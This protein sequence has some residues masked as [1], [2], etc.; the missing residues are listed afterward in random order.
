MR[1][2]VTG[3]GGEPA[4]DLSSD[5]WSV[6]ARALET[7]GF[8]LV[9]DQ[10]GSSFD[11]LVAMNHSK[12]AID[13]S[14]RLGVPI[15]KRALILWEPRVVS[16]GMYNKKI[17]SRYGFVYSPSPLRTVGTESRTFS[18]ISR[19]STCQKLPAAD[20]LSSAYM[21]NGNKYSFVESELYTLRRQ[22][23]SACRST[24]VPFDLWGTN[25]DL[26]LARKA[27]LLS[28]CLADCVRSGLTPNPNSFRALS[29]RNFRSKGSVGSKFDIAPSYKVGVVVENQADYVSEKLYD[30]IDAGNVAIY[31][32]PPLEDFSLRGAA[33]EVQPVTELIVAEIQRVLGLDNH[34]LE[35]I[36][37]QQS[38]ALRERRSWG[39]LGD[40][41]VSMAKSLARDLQGTFR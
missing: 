33:I 11:A 23:V 24:G 31:V 19:P 12:R 32:G 41:V 13:E 14:E 36:R 21:I 7:E 18:W 26:S 27:K 15:D 29:T 40:E 30:T 39:D 37:D 3:F 5:V 20:Q 38:E 28:Y 1:L 34:E 17:L 4:L 10:Y 2:R 35:T 16:P 9:R 25:W 22:I 6:F 8:E